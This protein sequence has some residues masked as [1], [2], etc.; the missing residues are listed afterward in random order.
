[1]TV[2]HTYASVDFLRD[3]LAG[4]SYASGWTADA[5][6]LLTILERSSLIVNGFV[7]DQSFGPTTQT[8][9][10][11]VGTGPLIYD[12]RPWFPNHG[13]IEI[14]RSRHAVLPLDR[15]LLTATTVTSYSGTD[16]ATSQTLTEGL[17]N[18]YLL[19]PYQSNDLGSRYWRLKLSTE[20]TNAFNAGQQTLVIAGV[21]GWSQDTSPTT[22]T[23]SSAIT[24]TTATTVAVTSGAVFSPGNTLVVDSE[25]MYVS[26]ISTNDLTVIRGVNGT[27]A[28]VHDNASTV[29]RYIY[30]ADVTMVAADIA[31]ILYRDRDLGVLE[32]IGSG[33][34]AIRVR[35]QVEIDNAL[36]TLDRYRVARHAAGVIF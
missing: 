14:T 10:Y 33:E 20:S 34:Q 1:M 15:W 7:G 25:Q 26:S 11:D 17:S 23:L 5:V 32:T 27:T 28:A 36:R 35:P 9:S 19:E 18:D 2:F 30:P 31:R 3:T 22:T 8:R 12:E 13:G 21:W 6:M 4:T 24:S 29:A 16:R